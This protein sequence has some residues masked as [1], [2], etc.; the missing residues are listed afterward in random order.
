VGKD[1]L[2]M[3]FVLTT[4]VLLAHITVLIIA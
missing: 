2:Q 3:R 4:L 1:Y